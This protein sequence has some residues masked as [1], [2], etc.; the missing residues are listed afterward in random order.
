MTRPP[1]PGASRV[2]IA[3]LV[4]VAAA[5]TTLAAPQAP[6]PAFPAFSDAASLK[7]AC[8]RGLATATQSLRELE[9]HPADGRWL[10]A[11]DRFNAQLEDLGYPLQFLSA[12]HPDKPVREASEACEQRWTEFQSSLGQNEKLFKAARQ[13]KPRDAIDSELLKTLIEGF[14]DAGV[15]LPPAQRERAKALIDR[16]SALGIEF[17]RNVRDAAIT[18][19]FTEAELKGVPDAL[20]K[21]AKRDDQGRVLLG[22]D[23][24]TYFPVMQLAEDG[25]ARERIWRAKTN[26][27]GEGNLKLL[28]EITKLRTEY[29]ALFGA[30]SWAEFTVR[31]RMAESVPRA[32]AFLADVKA[33]VEDRERRE[34]DELRRAKAEHL[35][36]PLDAVRIERWDVPFYTE[37]V[38]KARYSVDQEAFR[39]YFPPQES[40]QFCLRLIEKLMGVRYE[41]VPGVALWHPEAQTY[42]VSDAASGKALATLW[43]DLYPRDGKYNHA[44]VWGLRSSSVA[45]K[46]TSQAALVVNFDR[47][48]L[49]LDELETLLHELG[50]SVHNNLSATRYSQQ[51]G[52]SVKRDFVEAPS[53]MLEDWV[54]DKQVLKLFAE[55]C[56]ACKP[57]PDAL[58]DQ[59]RAA[60]D[61]GKGVQQSRQHLY[62]S[63]DLALYSGQARDPLALWAAMEGATPLGHIRG[64]MFP[65]GF[66]HIA[67]NYSAG[68]YGYLWSLVVAMDMRTAFDGKRLDAGVGRRYRN[69]VLAN[70]S[71]RPPSAIVK[72]FLGR[73]FS[74]KAFFEDLKK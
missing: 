9:R 60:R 50:H 52:T 56:P 15:A 35:G 27:G 68:Y 29:A 54:Y 53:Q 28:A 22:V 14:E 4:L 67:T 38:R 8:E 20:W 33:A 26:E 44:A 57:V 12:V 17:D 65:A 36:Q 74:S 59:A 41:R 11:Y 61:Y 3:S 32:Q 73:D 64:T 70:G 45:L 49:T 43:I 30:S 62:A 46:R 42:R 18:V 39:Q 63:Y 47:K 19:P 23:Y 58:I 1:F 24:P 72:E 37:R 31:R 66:S 71:Q 16:V 2:A 21:S 5:S 69:V 13:V 10:L 6:G 25:A 7:A 51:A 34:I 55:V 40:L 48:G